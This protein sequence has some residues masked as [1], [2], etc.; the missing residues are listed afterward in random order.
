MSKLLVK[1]DQKNITIPNQ[2]CCADGASAIVSIEGMIV[3]HRYYCQLFSMSRGTVSFIQNNF[4][5]VAQTTNATLPLGFVLKDS[6][7][8]IIKFKITDVDSRQA[9]KYWIP[10]KHEWYKAAYYNPVSESY[11][12]YA[13]QNNTAPSNVT[14]T[15]NGDGSAGNTGNF[16]NFGKE[17]DWND[18]D[19]NLTTVGTNGGPSYYGTFDQNGNINEWVDD[20]S[21]RHKPYMGGSW[22]SSLSGLK[23]IVDVPV[24]FESDS[25]GLRI[26]AAFNKD[27]IV[28]TDQYAMVSGSF[29][30]ESQNYFTEIDGGNAPFYVSDTDIDGGVSFSNASDTNGIGSV[31]Y[32]FYIKK[33]PVTNNEYVIFLNSTA[34]KSDKYGLYNTKMA[35]DPRGGIIRY[36]NSDQ[37]FRYVCKDGMENKPV[38]FVSWLDGARYCNWLYNLSIDANINETEKGAYNML[39][40]SKDAPYI[41]LNY[42]EDILTIQCGE[43]SGHTVAFTDATLDMVDKVP[44]N[45][46]KHIIAV[47]NNAKIGREYAYSFTFPDSS[48]TTVIPQ[49]GTI[50][51]GSNQQNIN[52]VHSYTGSL[53]K[54]DLKL[55]VIDLIDNIRT[56]TSISFDCVK[57]KPD[58]TP[59]PTSMPIPTPTPTSNNN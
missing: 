17:A 3:G 53:K 7:S 46:A 37:S 6:R 59:T 40:D 1:F 4:Y 41:G 8:H 11:N 20:I 19:G 51:A 33:Y 21:V 23:D 45:S 31:Y 10:N 52:T 38:N 26:A 39:S 14:A 13:T 47:I 9:Y 15:Y 54:V 27:L 42:G 30:I 22:N 57:C 49:S 29:T 34:S 5:I 48:F 56:N 25:V 58:P 24:G 43:V 50:K 28:D 2:S 35:T 12:I 44:C 32:P 18:L 55:D 36:I 16:A